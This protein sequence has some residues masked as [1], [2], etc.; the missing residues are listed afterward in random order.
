MPVES[1][2]ILDAVAVRIGTRVLMAGGT[3]M[4]R[5]GMVRGNVAG[6]VAGTVVRAVADGLS[7]AGSVAVPFGDFAGACG[8]LVDDANEGP[9]DADR[10]SVGLCRACPEAGRRRFGRR[11]SRG[12]LTLR[13]TWTYNPA[14]VSPATGVHTGKIPQ[15]ASCSRFE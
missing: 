6:H 3:E 14:P 7:M 1:A 2:E 10:L 4:G 12:L 11:Y 13:K 15:P 9:G 8:L 5:R